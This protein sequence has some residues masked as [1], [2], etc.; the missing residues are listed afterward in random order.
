M[1]C[2][3]CGGGGTAVNGGDQYQAIAGDGTVLPI[4]GNRMTGTKEEAR[5]IVAGQA[6]GWV[7]KA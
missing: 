1:G 6:G 5:A 4:D 2:N 3:S 7:R